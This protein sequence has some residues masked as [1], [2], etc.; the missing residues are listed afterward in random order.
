[1]KLSTEGGIA[2]T[3]EGK[4]RWRIRL[5]NNIN[6]SNNS[7]NIN[8]SNI[9]SNIHPRLFFKKNLETQVRKVEEWGQFNNAFVENFMIFQQIPVTDFQLFVVVNEPVR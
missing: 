9:G 6:N 1:M 4:W 3:K 5:N 7:N 2:Q 8:N